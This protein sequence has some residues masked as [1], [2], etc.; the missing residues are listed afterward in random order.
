MDAGAAG[1]SVAKD[2]QAQG[3]TTP[4]R[5]AILMLVAIGQMADFL[6]FAAA[7]SVVPIAAESAG[8]ARLAYAAYGLMGVF[9]VKTLFLIPML[10][11]VDYIIRGKSALAW[12][13]FVSTFVFAWG[14][15]GAATNLGAIALALR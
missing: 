14:L 10:L 12:K 4:V 3:V 7:A 11:I 9:M 2:Q 5:V 8:W 13:V 15:A 1:R 6:T